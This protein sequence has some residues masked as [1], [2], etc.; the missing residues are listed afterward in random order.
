MSVQY[1]PAAFVNGATIYTVV[2]PGDASF[3]ST[4]SGVTAVSVDLLPFF[5]VIAAITGATLGSLYTRRMRGKAVFGPLRRRRANAVAEQTITVA[6]EASLPETRALNQKQSA[7]EITPAV[8]VIAEKPPQEAPKLE[9][10]L[11][12][13]TTAPFVDET[14]PAPML[15]PLEPQHSRT[16]GYIKTVALEKRFGASKVVD[17]FSLHVDKGEIYGLLGPNDA[18]K[19]TLIKLL[20]GR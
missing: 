14:P 4:P 15:P 8:D 11:P 13:E 3:I 19:T 20:C 9:P 12:D 1:F 6:A 16:N 7:E 10:P 18:G 5:L 17:D 2:G